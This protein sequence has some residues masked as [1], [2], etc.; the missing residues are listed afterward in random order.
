MMEGMK[1]SK[2]EELKEILKLIKD[3]ISV[4]EKTI[5]RKDAEIRELEDIIQLGV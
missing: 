3:K 1:V 4:T 2:V 5:K